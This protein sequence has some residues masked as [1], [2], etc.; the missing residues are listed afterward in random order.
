MSAP[1]LQ[2]QQPRFHRDCKIKKTVWW[3]GGS[4]TTK[5]PSGLLSV[6]D[7]ASLSQAGPAEASGLRPSALASRS[8]ALI[9]SYFVTFFKTE[10]IQKL[11]TKKIVVQERTVVSQFH[12]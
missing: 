10:D 7:F 8:P 11:S 9:F 5:P 6:P 12:S 4:V 1:I 2:N 3:Y